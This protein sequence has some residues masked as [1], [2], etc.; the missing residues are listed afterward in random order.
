MYI[1]TRVFD[2][3]GTGISPEV[4]TLVLQ[5]QFRN[6]G[7]VHISL[8]RTMSLEMLRAILGMHFLF[9]HMLTHLSLLDL[10]TLIIHS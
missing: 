5:D 1:I 2:R 8:S 6:Y 9:P 3:E 7:L 4:Y 10:V